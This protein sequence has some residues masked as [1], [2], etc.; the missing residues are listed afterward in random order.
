MSPEI[1]SRSKAVGLVLAVFLLDQILKAWAFAQDFSWSWSFIG[2]VHHKNEGALANI[3][4]DR[5][6]LIIIT[7]IV[8]SFIIRWMVEAIKVNKK[9][10]YIGLALV[11]GGAVGNLYDRIAFGFVR[12]WI[13]LFGRSAI[14]IADMAI[15]IGGILYLASRWKEKRHLVHNQEKNG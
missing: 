14:N 2:L 3:P 10:E 11:L 9:I 13:V 4:I 8:A 7:F 15:A 1:K 5:T 12:D 6:W